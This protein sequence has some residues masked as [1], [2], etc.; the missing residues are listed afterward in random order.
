MIRSATHR[1]PK[2]AQDTF[3]ITPEKETPMAD[4]A[5]APVHKVDEEGTY[6]LTGA[7]LYK[8]HHFRAEDRLTLLQNELFKLAN[9]YGW[10]L[11]AW[12]VFSNHYHFVALSPENPENL[13]DMVTELHQS[14]ATDINGKDNARGRTVW[15]NYW[16]TQITYQKS[17]LARLK[18]V[19]YNP[20]KHGLVED[21]VNYRWC[22]ASWFEQHASLAFQKTVGSFKI[23]RVNVFDEFEPVLPQY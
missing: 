23:D 4:W 12:A 15:Y 18:Y 14:T 22:S 7:T 16:D 1:T 19:H 21:P 13:E 5:H 3:T 11:Q 10:L 6:F 9:Q 17:Y 20:V 2:L 8:R